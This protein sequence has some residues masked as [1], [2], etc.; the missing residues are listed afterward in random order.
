[1]SVLRRAPCPAGVIGRNLKCLGCYNLKVGDGSGSWDW[2]KK[3][4][5]DGKIKGEEFGLEG[6]TERRKGAATC[7]SKRCALVRWKG[8]SCWISHRSARTKVWWPLSLQC[9]ISGGF[10]NF[11]LLDPVSQ[12]MWTG[13]LS[14]MAS[15]F[16]LYKNQFSVAMRNAAFSPP[17]EGFSASWSIS[18]ICMFYQSSVQ[19]WWWKPLLMHSKALRNHLTEEEGVQK[20]KEVNMC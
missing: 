5:E 18:R 19:K 8:E 6:S 12:G 13:T 4:A 17:L 3:K 9:V 1:M 14:R 7:L 15:K 20:W 2:N 11:S 16:K 10:T